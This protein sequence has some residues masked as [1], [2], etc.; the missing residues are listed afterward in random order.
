MS[1]TVIEN[2]PFLCDSLSRNIVNANVLVLCYELWAKV[3][4]M[5][6][7]VLRACIILLSL[8]ATSSGVYAL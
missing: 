4:E 6:A 1:L 3:L 5:S 8:N 7:C 2:L